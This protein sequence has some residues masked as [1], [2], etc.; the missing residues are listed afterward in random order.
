MT[1]ERDT[2]DEG[3]HGDGGPTLLFAVINHSSHT[4]RS[5]KQEPLPRQNKKEKEMIPIHIHVYLK[6]ISTYTHTAI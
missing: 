1:F 3:G 5:A 4:Q 6:C 2:E